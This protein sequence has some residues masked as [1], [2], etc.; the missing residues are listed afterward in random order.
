[1]DS[2]ETKQELMTYA[3]DLLDYAEKIPVID[4]KKDFVTALNPE[5]DLRDFLGTPD[6]DAL[7]I[8]EEYGYSLVSFEVWLSDINMISKGKS[9]TIIEFLNEIEKDDL[10]YMRCLVNLQ[11]FR[12][13]NVL[14][15]ASLN[16]IM[17]S[18][19]KE[20]Y[21]EWG[22]LL[23]ALEKQ[24]GYYKDWLREHLTHIN[25]KYQEIRKKDKELNDAER[26]FYVLLMKLLEREIHVS[27]GTL[28]D[29]EGNPVIRTYMR[30]FDKRSQ[31][32]LEDLDQIFDTVLKVDFSVM[33]D[34][35]EKD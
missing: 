16:R 22:R 8:C 11:D 21:D 14:D 4:S 12:M 10:I 13:M 3:I 18:D 27:T 19:K 6:L 28:H 24:D 20:V 7:S 15:A 30:V 25:Q 31:S 34:D 26:D 32:Y 35:G 2:E 29:D 33:E 23:T 1:M 5:V 17:N 9:V